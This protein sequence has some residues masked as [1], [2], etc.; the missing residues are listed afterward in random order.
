MSTSERGK[1]KLAGRGGNSGPG[2]PESDEDGERH[3]SH[4]QRGERDVEVE[5]SAGHRG[6]ADPRQA[7]RHRE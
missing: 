7:L 3:H 1:R 6:A 4:R 5:E 2:A